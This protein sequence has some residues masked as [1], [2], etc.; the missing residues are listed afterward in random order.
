MERRLLAAV[1][2]LATLAVPL[3]CF[4]E[5]SNEAPQG[6]PEVLELKIGEKGRFHEIGLATI[7]H[8]K[9]KGS[10]RLTTEDGMEF[11]VTFPKKLKELF[12]K[13]GISPPDVPDLR[14]LPAAFA[15]S[16]D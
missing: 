8:N 6:A 14:S 11:K 5:P 15:G 13:K 1:A 16:H 7:E 10:L 9:E 2:L 12:A 4:A 3:P